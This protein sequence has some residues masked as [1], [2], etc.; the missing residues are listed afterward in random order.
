MKPFHIFLLIIITASLS[1][2]LGWFMR[3]D[4]I[5]SKM[6]DQSAMVMGEMK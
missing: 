2:A 5:Y 3:G 6:F 1:F 4:M